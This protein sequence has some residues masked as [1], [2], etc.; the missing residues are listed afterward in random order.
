MKGFLAVQALKQ[1]VVDFVYV[2]FASGGPRNTHG[3]H[4]KSAGLGESLRLE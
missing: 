2:R 3:W 4:M 1:G